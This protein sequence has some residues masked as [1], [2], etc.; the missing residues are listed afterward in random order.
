M[1]AWLT[2]AGLSVAVLTACG[3]SAS[4]SSPTSA[5]G[6]TPSAASPSPTPTAAREPRLVI[7][8]RGTNPPATD[9]VRLAG[10]D[11]NDAGTMAGHFMGVFDDRAVALNGLVLTAMAYD[12]A[13]THLGTLVH[14]PSGFTDQVVVSPDLS[15]WLYT[16]TSDTQSLTAQ[17]HVGSASADHVVATL[18]SPDSN[19][20]FAPYA[21]NSS[22]VY[23]IL[24]AT[25][26]GGAGPFLDYHF[27]LYRFDVGTG[28]VSQ[29]KPV[30]EAYDVLPSGA[31]VCA[32][33]GG[34]SQMTSGLTIRSAGTAD[35]VVPVQG[36]FA[37]VK[38]SPDSSRLSLVGLGGT[39]ADAEYQVRTTV[40]TTPVLSD[41]GPPGYVPAAWLP[42]GRMV[43]RKMC[44]VADNSP[45]ACD[46]ARDGETYI[47]TAD[48]S[49]STLFF[50]FGEG[51]R[52]VDVLV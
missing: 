6:T 41:F 49:S 13:T 16:T 39:S 50:K 48:G 51:V 8:D 3:S 37:G 18:P 25:G 9:R 23:L 24:Q 2:L 38:L 4:P 35:R 36:P 27:P 45:T 15:Q 12:G 11:A 47:V 44:L 28:A 26:I 46:A 1:R 43:T 19:G 22:G 32:L 29:V 40:L 42:D 30:C 17:V 7:E 21:W 31:L 10:L 34:G 5:A 20:I 33:S 52:V 14:A